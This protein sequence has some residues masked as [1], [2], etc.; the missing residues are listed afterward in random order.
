MNDPVDPKKVAEFQKSIL[1]AFKKRRNEIPPAFRPDHVYF[2]P[3]PHVSQRLTEGN[4]PE[5]WHGDPLTFTADEQKRLTMFL[6]SAQYAAEAVRKEFP[7]L[8]ILIPWGDALFAVP[9]LRA[10]FP[11]T[12][13]DG[14]G[15]DT[16]GFERLPEMVSVR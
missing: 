2:F 5:Y 6:R 13:I 9:L 10:G 15:I 4:Y 16:P 11:K 7:D 1:E 14:S 12:L 3:E 8:K